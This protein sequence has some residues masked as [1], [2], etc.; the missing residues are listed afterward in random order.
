MRL[1]YTLGLL[2]VGG[3]EMRSLRLF[4]DLRDRKLDINCTIYI[5]S[6]QKGV[7][8]S[9]F[10]EL[11]LK[12]VYG[13]PGLVGLIHLW[14]F[15]IMFRPSI[16]HTNVSTANGFYAL[17][18]KIAGVPI[19]ISHYRS[20]EDIRPGLM[21]QAKA[22]LGRFLSNRLS[23]NVI[24]VCQ[25]AQKF[26]RAPNNKWFTLY[27]GIDLPNYDDVGHR[28]TCLTI[29]YLGRISTEKNPH[30]ALDIL[31]A[32][33]KDDRGQNVRLRFAGSGSTDQIEA[34]AA[35]VRVRGLD[36]YVELCGVTD[37]PIEFLR[38]ASV[39]LLPSHREGLPGAALESLSV[40]VPVVAND[41]PG[42]REIS[43]SVKGV[44]VRNLSAGDDVWA[45][46]V[47]DAAAADR[48]EIAASFAGSTFLIHRHVEQVIS[49]WGL[50]SGWKE[51][52]LG[53]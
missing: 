17:A 30:R 22:K 40:G 2:D 27:N 26:A 49:L 5:I 51:M 24:G 45:E 3:A 8:D 43:A 6:G 11:G 50:K 20:L 13:R 31:E 35:D 34:L 1:V 10:S 53:D 48:R 38:N 4:R 18:A 33:L 29:G 28:P 42:V 36:N 12:L 9:R 39:L 52:S 23:R 15:L 19:V 46:A 41:L 32:V 21:N 37:E 14:C 44:Y 25:A 47:F 7:L 16:F